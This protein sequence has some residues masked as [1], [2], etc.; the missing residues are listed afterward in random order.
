MMHIRSARPIQIA[1][2]HEGPPNAR[3]LKVMNFSCQE[4]WGI[5]NNYEDLLSVFKYD[6]LWN[7]KCI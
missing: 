2:R 3:Q 7:H 6:P 1:F 4:G 5:R